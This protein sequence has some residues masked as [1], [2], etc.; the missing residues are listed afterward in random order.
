MG[1]EAI[2][3]HFDTDHILDV[4]TDDVLSQGGDIVIKDMLNDHRHGATTQWDIVREVLRMA[5][6]G[7][8]QSQHGRDLVVGLLDRFVAE[9]KARMLVEIELTAAGL[10]EEEIE[11]ALRDYPEHFTPEGIATRRAANQQLPQDGSTAI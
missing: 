2:M 9:S 1:K 5:L 8:A 3:A 11:E 7:S 4:L 10:D 6:V